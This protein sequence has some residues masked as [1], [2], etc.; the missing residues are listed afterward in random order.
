L[1]YITNAIIH[2]SREK[3]NNSSNGEDV[4]KKETLDCSHP[5]PL[6]FTP[7][8]PRGKG[9]DEEQTAASLACPH[10]MAHLDRQLS[11]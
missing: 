9:W 4:S 10:Q 8:P 6:S 11:R 3:V 7:F 2:I 5:A 1:V